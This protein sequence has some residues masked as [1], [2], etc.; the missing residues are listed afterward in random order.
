MSELSLPERIVHAAEEA[1]D[2]ARVCGLTE[3]NR[4]VYVEGYL[5]DFAKA[6]ANA[7]IEELAKVLE[8]QMCCGRE[9]STQCFKCGQLHSEIW[10]LQALAQAVRD[11]PALKAV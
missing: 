2:M 8:G 7:V 9:P 5:L 11:A 3:G 10:D 4:P 1:I 6:S